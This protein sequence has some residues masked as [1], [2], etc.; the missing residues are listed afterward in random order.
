[1]K[2]CQLLNKFFKFAHV[3]FSCALQSRYTFLT[4][5]I[6]PTFIICMK[7]FRKVSHILIYNLFYMWRSKVTKQTHTLKGKVLS[8]RVVWTELALNSPE[9]DYVNRTVKFRAIH[10]SVKNH[11]LSAILMVRL[12]SLAKKKAHVMHMKICMV[13]VVPPYSITIRKYTHWI[14]YNNIGEV[15]IGWYKHVVACFIQGKRPEFPTRENWLIN[16]LL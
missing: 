2:S 5:V 4:N 3:C 1:M 10:R 15:K 16:W 8:R 14:P 6:L 12:I 7:R 13:S 9:F 11:R